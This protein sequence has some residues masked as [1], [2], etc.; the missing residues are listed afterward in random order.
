[1]NY[2]LRREYEVIPA[3]TREVGETEKQKEAWRGMVA[4]Q[5]ER[6]KLCSGDMRLCW[7]RSILKLAVAGLTQNS[8]REYQ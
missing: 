4:A 2:I 3:G 7:M 5:Q 1:M 8:G 6:L